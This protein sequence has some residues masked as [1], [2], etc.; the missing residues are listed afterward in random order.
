MAG[1]DASARSVI[2][3]HETYMDELGVVVLNDELLDQLDRHAAPSH[4]RT[5]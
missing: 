2:R 5:S 4:H 3:A 1:D